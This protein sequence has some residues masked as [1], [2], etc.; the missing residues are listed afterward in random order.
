M[1]TDFAF[2]ERGSGDAILL[3]HG[4]VFSDWFAPVAARPEMDEFRVIRMR[5]AGYGQGSVHAGHLTLADHAAH[6]SQLL[7]DLEIDTAHVCGHSSGALIALELALCRPDAVQSLV[8]LEPAPVSALAGPQCQSAVPAALGPVMVAAAGGDIAGAFDL[9]L[10]AV[11]R[12]DYRAVLDATL[13]PDGYEHALQESGFFFSDEI[14]ATME[15]VFGPDEAS[16][17]EQPMLVVEGGETAAVSMIPPESVK[18]LAE[19]V[20]HAETSAL[21]G[22]SHLMPLEDPGGVARLI[23]EFARRHEPGRGYPGAP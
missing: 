17:I 5:R 3:V 4:G 23:V 18:L 9:F 10:R 16:R 20:P 21:P 15:W 22:A 19:R 13:G 2:V 12:Q 7:D 8:L 14:P 11:G 1:T 6:C